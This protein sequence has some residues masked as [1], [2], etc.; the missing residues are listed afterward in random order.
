MAE[1]LH[2]LADTFPSNDYDIPVVK[3]M[4]GTVV[5]Q[6]WL[7]AYLSHVAKLTLTRDRHWQA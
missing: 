4:S 1:Q 7:E 2:Y 5:H 6:P 3:G